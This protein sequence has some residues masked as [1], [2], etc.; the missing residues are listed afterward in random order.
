[1]YAVKGRIPAQLPRPEAVRRTIP[2]R[3]GAAGSGAATNAA[4]CAAIAYYQL[5]TT[6]ALAA[7]DCFVVG[8][9]ALSRFETFG[10][11]LRAALFAVP[12]LIIAP[13]STGRAPPLSQMFWPFVENRNSCQRRAAAGCGAYLLTAWS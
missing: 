11:A 8:M 7:T 5:L 1:M 2:R 4:S 13:S 6:Y 3:R 10:R 12:A 9:T